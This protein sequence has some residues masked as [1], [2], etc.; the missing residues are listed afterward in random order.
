[1]VNA[2]SHGSVAAAASQVNS[3]EGAYDASNGFSSQVATS[4]DTNPH[5]LYGLASNPGR[6]QTKTCLVYEI[7]VYNHSGAQCTVHLELGDGTERS[8]HIV[9]GNTAT[10]Q[11]SLGKPIVFQATEE[12]WYQASAADIDVQVTGLEV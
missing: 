9:V 3:S 12:V 5:V 6:D 1:M 2:A 7:M 8:V 11:M 4:P 10:A